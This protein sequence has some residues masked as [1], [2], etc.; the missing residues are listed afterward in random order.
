MN[1]AISILMTF[2]LG[3]MTIKDFTQEKYI[4]VC[5]FLVETLLYIFWVI[6]LSIKNDKR[7]KKLKEA[8]KEMKAKL[9]EAEKIIE[10]NR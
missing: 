2:L 7:D 1:T 5:I 8:E 10:N 9:K 3:I 4:F 6:P